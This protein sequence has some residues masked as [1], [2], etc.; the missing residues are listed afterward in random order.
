MGEEFDCDYTDEPVCPYCGEEQSDFWEMM[1]DD[2]LVD[3]QECEKEFR[4]VRITEV[5]YCTEKKEAKA[6][7]N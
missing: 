6:D 7:G 3:C 5:H 4:Y 2:G 1:D